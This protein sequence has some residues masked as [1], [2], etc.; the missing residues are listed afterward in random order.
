MLSR[1]SLNGLV[2]PAR[3]NGA[4]FTTAENSRLDRDIDIGGQARNKRHANFYLG[5]AVLGFFRPVF[6]IKFPIDDLDIIQR[7]PR[8]RSR[9]SLGEFVDQVLIVIR[10]V[11]ISDQADIRFRHPQR[12]DHRC[13]TKQGLKLE[14]DEQLIERYR[15]TIALPLAHHEAA[16]GQT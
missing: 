2:S 11:F 1:E 9:G 16:D 13:Q 4:P 5:N 10:S 12:F 6:E 8:W 7:E 15:G 14:I 3:W